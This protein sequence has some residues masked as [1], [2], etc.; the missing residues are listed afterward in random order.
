MRWVQ[1]IIPFWFL[2]VR[3]QFCRFFFLYDPAWF[4]LYYVLCVFVVLTV[5][6]LDDN[7][8]LVSLEPFGL[9]LRVCASPEYRRNGYCMIEYCMI[10][11][12]W[13]VP[14]FCSSILTA[15]CRA[16]VHHISY[17]ASGKRRVAFHAIMCNLRASVELQSASCASMRLGAIFLG[18]WARW[19]VQS[20]AVYP[21][22]YSIAHGVSW[23][24]GVRVAVGL[25][26]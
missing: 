15:E 18:G 21:W 2:L 14:P 25:G 1:C 4:G 6:S 16:I 13:V 9:G 26:L 23:Q 10:G 7:T 22:I 20:P 19:T 5:R 12:L 24:A 11:G 8:I 17:V 3:I